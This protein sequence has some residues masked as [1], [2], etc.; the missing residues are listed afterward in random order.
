MVRVFIKVETSGSFN[1]SGLIY[2]WLEDDG[3]SV[4][5]IGAMNR[6]NKPEYHFDEKTLTFFDNGIVSVNALDTIEG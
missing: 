6:P 2:E 4:A 5:L 1:A 3:K